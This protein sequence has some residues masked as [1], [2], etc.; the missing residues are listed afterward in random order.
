MV[1]SPSPRRRTASIQ[2]GPADIRQAPCGGAA[3]RLRRKMAAPMLRDVDAAAEPDVLMARHVREQLDQAAG[4]AGAADQAVVQADRQQLR[5][6]RNAFR[7][8]QVEGV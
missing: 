8:K 5:R 7:V 2:S 1:A 6:S 3:S 4:A